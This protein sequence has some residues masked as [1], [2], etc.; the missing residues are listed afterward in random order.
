[1]DKSVL[2]WILF[3]ALGFA[4]ALA[5]QMRVLIALVLRR[6]LKAWNADLDNR[7]KANLVVVQAAARTSDTVEQEPW[8]QKSVA[9][10]RETYPAPLKQIQIAR[11]F[12]VLIPVLM[13]AYLAI[14]RFSLGVF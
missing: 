12:S 3:G 4:F 7:E 8:L 1:M 13:I 14:G 10:L 5:V 2:F 9:H 6:A 11:R